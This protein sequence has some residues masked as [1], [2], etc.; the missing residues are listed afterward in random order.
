[1]NVVI[2]SE[3]IKSGKACAILFQIV[4]YIVIVPIIYYDIFEGNYCEISKND[5]KIF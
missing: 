4:K 3:R 1:M 2:N 5:K